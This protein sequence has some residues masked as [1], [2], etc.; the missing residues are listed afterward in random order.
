[1]QRPPIETSCPRT[2][3]YL[4]TGTVQEISRV[5]C[6]SGKINSYIGAAV[7]AKFELSQKKKSDLLT[8]EVTARKN[9]AIFG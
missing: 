1:M 7:C 2:C 8:I 4:W 5:R 6:A 3:Q 9:D